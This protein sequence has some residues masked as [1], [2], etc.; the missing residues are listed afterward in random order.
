MRSKCLF[1]VCLM[2]RK[3]VPQVKLWSVVLSGKFPHDKS[4]F[5]C[6]PKIFHCYH[7]RFQSKSNQNIILYYYI[8]DRDTWTKPFLRLIIQTG[9]QRQKEA[10]YWTQIFPLPLGYT[11][12]YWHTNGQGASNPGAPWSPLSPLAPLL[13]FLPLSPCKQQCINKKTNFS[14]PN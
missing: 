2:E 14:P 7:K 5:K 3:E 1:S 10:N 13:P 11:L 8:S 12:D 9:Y 6:L 4:T